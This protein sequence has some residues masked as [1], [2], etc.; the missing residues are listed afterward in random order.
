M[1]IAIDTSVLVGLINPSDHRHSQAMA[2]CNALIA[3]NAEFVYFD[4]IAA[5][6]VSVVV[7]RL[8]EKNRRAEL[9][10]RPAGAGLP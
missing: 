9:Q 7:R 1:K 3:A 8:E 4:C 5:E 6:T 10:R 2:L